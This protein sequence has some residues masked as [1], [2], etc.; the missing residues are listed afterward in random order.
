[1]TAQS[2]FDTFFSVPVDWPS[3]H[4]CWLMVSSLHTFSSAGA[5]SACGRT[6][7]LRESSSYEAPQL[8]WHKIVFNLKNAE[9]VQARL[10]TLL[11]IWVSCEELCFYK[12]ALACLDTLSLCLVWGFGWGVLDFIA[13]TLNRRSTCFPNTHIT[14]LHPVE[15]KAI[16]S[17]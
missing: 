5:W 8:W 12:T 2:Q 4:V 14:R 1:M 10:L 16:V 6:K 17:H 11:Q 7:H 15:N 3:V 9:P 13:Q